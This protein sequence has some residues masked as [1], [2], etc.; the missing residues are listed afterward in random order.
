MQS[1]LI[2]LGVFFCLGCTPLCAGILDTVHRS[3]KSTQTH[4]KSD[5]D[6]QNTQGSGKSGG[7]QK[8]DTGDGAQSSKK[9]QT[10][11][12]TDGEDHN[13]A[14]GKK[15]QSR[16]TSPKKEPPNAAENVLN[17]RHNAS[18]QQ[19]EMASGQ[20]SA[21]MGSIKN[22]T[23][24]KP[25]KGRTSSFGPS[26]KKG[27]AGAKNAS[28]SAAK[29]AAAGFPSGQKSLDFLK[30]VMPGAPG[31]ASLFCRKMCNRFTCHI[32]AMKAMC[33]S[34]CWKYPGA[35]KNCLKAG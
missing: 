7:N 5:S 20:P 23:A 31:E 14:S 34:K 2:L 29:N 15:G 25:K 21:A 9:G 22:G 10:S 18:K 1:K 32:G 30:G 19:A 24:A 16:N 28:K 33:A 11:G 26:A 35:I 4:S 6:N 13:N 17:T 12:S 8:G 27:F 3:D